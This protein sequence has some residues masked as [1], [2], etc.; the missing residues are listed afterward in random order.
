MNFIVTAITSLDAHSLVHDAPYVITSPN[1]PFVPYIDLHR[2]RELRARADGR[3]GLEDCFQCPQIYSNRHPWAPC[4]FRKPDSDVLAKHDFAL[5][6]WTPTLQFYELEPGCAFGDLGRLSK[7]AWDPLQQLQL[8]FTMRLRE[9]QEHH[10]IDPAANAY[11]FSMR[12]TLLRLRDQPLTWRDTV[13]QVAEFQRLCLDINAMLDFVAIY[14]P[15]LSISSDLPNPPANLNMMG[16]FTHDPEVASKLHRCGIPVWLIRQECHVP[17]TTKIVLKVTYIA[18]PPND[19]VEQR[20]WC[21]HHSSREMPF[22][23]LHLGTGGTSR[24][25][26]SRQMGSAFVD[27]PPIRH[28]AAD[29]DRSRDTSLPMQAPSGISFVP[30]PHSCSAEGMSVPSHAISAPSTP[31]ILIHSVLEEEPS[32]DAASSTAP[33]EL[34]ANNVPLYSALDEKSSSSA[35]QACPVATQ[36]AVTAGETPACP[37]P[38]HRVGS[39]GGSASS[40]VNK[41]RYSPCK[42]TLVPCDCKQVS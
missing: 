5:L 3:L 38:R 36:P 16:T 4:I 6:W 25:F 8:F 14:H 11:D 29:L 20:E 1:V 42:S 22:P 2:P 28:H 41:P 35:S 32:W 39:T 26:A 7:K 19:I 27:L 18:L 17:A 31:S 23:T 30:Q 12:S 34:D 37:A 10:S 9:Y 15:R 21:D 24:H 13:G 33:M 40:V